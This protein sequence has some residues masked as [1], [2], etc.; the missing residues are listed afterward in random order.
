MSIDRER[1]F[2]LNGSKHSVL[3]TARA[4]Y[5]FEKGT[6]YPLSNLR[7]FTGE[8]SD[9]E[10]AHLVLAGLEGFRVQSGQKRKRWT[11][12]EV[13]D[14][15]IGDANAGDRLAIVKACTE[16]VTDAFG[17]IETDDDDAEGKDQTTG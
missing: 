17:G 15:V 13:L 7:A 16:A 8:V 6:G 12:D 11:I 3:Y 4:R 2:G 10:Q 1:T 5:L 14:D 9:V